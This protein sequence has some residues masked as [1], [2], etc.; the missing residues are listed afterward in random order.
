MRIIGIPALNG[1]GKTVGTEQAPKAVV[2]KLKEEIFLNE[3]GFKPVWE[4]EQLAVDNFNIGETNRRIEERL[5]NCEEIPLIIGGD[6]SITYSCFKAFSRKFRNVGL[7]VFDAHPDVENSFSPPTHEDY[8]RMLIE[9]GFVRAENVVL[10]GTRSFDSNERDFLKGNRVQNFPMRLIAQEGISDACE[11]VME[12]AK[13]CGAVYVSI[14]IDVIDPAFAPGTGYIEPGGLTSREFLYFLNRLKNLKNLRAFD[15]V[16]INPTKDVAG[17][18]V[19]LGAKIVGEI[20]G[21]SG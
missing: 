4:F 19:K 12:L 16:E 3:N 20:L 11:S 2:E 13:N 5:N 18:T 10:V 14:D 1:L 15:V 7:V 8:L 17:M 6:H 9:E 21:Y